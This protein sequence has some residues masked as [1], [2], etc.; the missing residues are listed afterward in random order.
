MRLTRLSR[1]VTAKVTDQEFAEIEQ[2][3]AGRNR[4]ISEW[5]RDCLLRE[6]QRPRS[7]AEHETLLAEVLA[8]RSIMLNL[9]FRSNA[10]EKLTEQEMRELIQRSDQDKAQKARQRLTDAT[11]AETGDEYE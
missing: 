6:I 8:L 1:S 9:A 2:L 4:T 11:L 5:V 3:T 10:G 7:S